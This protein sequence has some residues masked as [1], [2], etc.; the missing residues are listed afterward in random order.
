MPALPQNTNENA[1]YLAWFPE[2]F[3]LLHHPMHKHCSKAVIYKS[4]FATKFEK[5]KRALS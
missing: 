2:A 1:L 4:L 5:S 3:L